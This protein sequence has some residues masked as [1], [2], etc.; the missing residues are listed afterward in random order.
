MTIDSTISDIVGIC[1]IKMDIEGS[2]LS[3][4]RGA[5]ETIR[6]YHP[7][8]SICIYHKMEDLLSIPLEIKSICESY[9]FIIRAGTHT[10]LYA[11]PLG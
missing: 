10:E 2:E 8:M 1:I 9:R 5:R 7:Y 6:Q 4:I 3:A 11:L